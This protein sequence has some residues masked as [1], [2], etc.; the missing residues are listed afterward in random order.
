MNADDLQLD[1]F[2]D[3]AIPQLYKAA[4]EPRQP[5]Q[6]TAMTVRG[7]AF[8]VLYQL[9]SSVLFSRELCEARLECAQAYFKW[10][11][12]SNWRAEEWL[13]LA[14]TFIWYP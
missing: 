5:P 8:H 2:S 6:T 9:D 4:L 14:N 3:I 12:K 13:L 10:V 11:V 1:G 7:L